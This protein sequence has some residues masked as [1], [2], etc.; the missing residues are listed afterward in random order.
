MDGHRF[1][2][3][4]RALTSGLSRRQTLTV[5]GAA[6]S[7]SGLRAALPEV[8]DALT[9]KQRRRCKRSGGTVCSAGTKASQC[10]ASKNGSD[11]PGTCVHGACSCDPTSTYADTNGCPFDANGSPGERCGCHAHNGGG[12][13]AD[14]NGACSE[15]QCDSDGDCPA[16]SVCFPGCAQSGETGRC[17]TPCTPA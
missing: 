4:T 17:S 7:G 2:G 15:T 5:L 13:C 16:G 1:D 9:R 12:V 10:C 6:L 14:R 8:A 3:L 11:G